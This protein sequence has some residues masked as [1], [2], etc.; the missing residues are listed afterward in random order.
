M[1]R[2]FEFCVVGLAC[3]VGSACTGIPVGTRAEVI[4]PDGGVN[5]TPDANT[6]ATSP[7]CPTEPHG[8]WVP[9]AA[10][11]APEARTKFASAWT[12]S[13]LLVW[14]GIN[15]AVAGEL[16]SGGAYRVD[17]GTWRSMSIVNAL[18]PRQNPCFVW[19]GTYA[20][21]WGGSNSDG[22]APPTD[23]SLYEPDTDV[24]TFPAT[25]GDAPIPRDSTTAIWTGELVVL[26]SGLNS[27]AIGLDSGAR[28]VLA[29]DT[30]LSMSQVGAPAPRYDHLAIW[31]GTRMLVWGG[32]YSNTVRN[33][34]GAYD[35]VSDTWS[36]INPEGGV[37]ALSPAGAWTGHELFV[38]GDSEPALYNPES[39][40]WRRPNMSGAPSP[41]SQP[42]VIWTGEVVIVWGG[43][44]NNVQLSDGALYDLAT[45][46]WAPMAEQ[47]AP[48][49]RTGRAVWAASINAMLVWGG[50]DWSTLDSLNDGAAF[51]PPVGN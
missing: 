40:T 20:W 23:V 24:W 13:E 21:N 22:D 2:A 46:T 33:S 38:W 28:Y 29:T 50:T 4:V 17:S 47:G 9:F 10:Q 25:Q 45:D 8:C 34:G 3:L 42:M 26:W 16:R 49:P 11:G 39:D 43:R 37:T 6:G 7:P 12:G 51:Y 30:W 41:R 48:S 14:G 36:P 5:T 19:T 18:M 35:P 15:T 27:G 44:W 1:D 31:T 32:G